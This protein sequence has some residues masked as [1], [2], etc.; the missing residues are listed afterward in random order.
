MAKYL[1]LTFGLLFMLLTTTSNA[2]DGCIIKNM[3][4]FSCESGRRLVS[5]LDSR[6]NVCVIHNDDA[7]EISGLYCK[8]P[9]GCYK[10]ETST[11]F[12]GD[13]IFSWYNCY[14]GARPI[15][16]NRSE[17]D[18]RSED[19]MLIGCVVKNVKDELCPSG[20]R[21]FSKKDMSLTACADYGI[22]STEI[23]GA[24]CMSSYPCMKDFQS[25][26]L[27]GESTYAWYNCQP[28]AVPIEK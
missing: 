17:E 14:P 16:N 25:V 12:E 23:P 21:L 8:S 9:Q 11:Y 3:L 2:N 26:Y 5:T 24:F 20:R 28:G 7:L 22:D 19:P 6:L 27:D 15:R 1:P 4:D 10:D 18:T 13:M